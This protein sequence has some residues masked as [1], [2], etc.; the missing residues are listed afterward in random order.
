MNRFTDIYDI[1][2]TLGE[3]SIDYPG[4]TPY[5]REY[6]STLK[7]GAPYDLSSLRMS[8][9]SG[10]HL[11]FPAHF[12]PGGNSAEDYTVADFIRPA[13]V[14][15]IRDPERI[16]PDELERLEIRPQEALLFKTDNSR[17]GRSKNGIFSE[18]YV[19]LSPEAA[20]YC[21][22]RDVGLV[23]IDYASIEQCGN[24]TF[25]A[26]RYLLGGNIPVLEG[27]D[28]ESVPTGTYTL[29]CLP[30]KIKGGEAA[31]VRAIL[32]R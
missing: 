6:L 18:Q 19:Y 10:T 24:D 22:Q 13:Q 4:D 25:A 15:D 12:I 5:S 9:H 16:V 7:D 8:S 17:T 11:D 14:I 28:L 31:P 29:Y 26:H 30:L 2:V 27:L 1:S 3:E 20:Q 32:M 21:V 23:G